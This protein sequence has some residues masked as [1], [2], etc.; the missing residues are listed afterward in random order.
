M[1]PL[2]QPCFSPPF[3]FYLKMFDPVPSF[4]LHPLFLSLHRLNSTLP[5]NVLSSSHNYTLRAEVSSIFQKG[6]SRPFQEDR[7]SKG[8]LV[9]AHKYRLKRKQLPYLLYFNTKML[10]LG[11]VQLFQHVVN[12]FFPWTLYIEGLNSSWNLSYW[13]DFWCF[14]SSQPT[15]FFNLLLSY[16]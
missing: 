9:T 11:R 12:S 1:W 6:S 2:P 8:P 4:Y 13:V 14:Y 10:M 3:R 16:Q 7:R 5:L 15:W